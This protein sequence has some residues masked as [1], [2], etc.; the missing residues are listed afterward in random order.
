MYRSL[1]ASLFIV[2]ACGPPS[3]NNNNNGTGTTGTTGETS[4]GPTGPVGPTEMIAMPTTISKT[5]DGNGGE[6]KL[7][8][9]GATLPP[10][11]L[12]ASTLI[13]V[14]QTDDTIPGYKLFSKV[15]AFEP[16]GLVFSS[17]LIVEIELTGDAT[18]GKFYW[19]RLNDPNTFDE[20]DGL[21]L[22]TTFTATV[23]H[24]SRGFVGDL[25]P[26][27]LV[28]NPPAAPSGLTAHPG[29]TEVDL[30]WAP[31]AGATL[32]KVLRSSTPGGPYT[33][34]TQVTSPSYTHGGL[35]NGTAQYYIVK[36]NNADGDGPASLEATAT[37]QQIEPPQNPGITAASGSLTITWQPP[38][39]ASTNTSYKVYKDGNLT[40][41]TPVPLTVLNFQDTSGIVNGVNHFY[42]VTS[43]NPAKTFESGPSAIVSGFA[44]KVPSGFSVTGPTGTTSATGPSGCRYNINWAANADGMHHFA[45]AVRITGGDFI[46]Q[47]DVL[48]ATHAIQ[49][50]LRYGSGQV[51][52]ATIAVRACYDAT[53][54]I[55]GGVEALFPV[56]FD[57]ACSGALACPPP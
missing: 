8:S 1:V 10:G 4:T 52:D 41:V 28:L 20:V 22:G 23:D 44:Y 56:V 34:L 5:L 18:N 14:R 13:T 40:S 24:F 50:A 7:G 27:V 35:T 29:D 51:N 43:L 48:E 30:T 2:A 25:L 6:V 57:N 39:H 46:N 53:P 32:Y 9:S 11:A 37:P 12:T 3:A 36:G 55:C 45:V 38:P 16:E 42:E 19:S 54:S 21:L 33:A 47:P 26:V 15:W 49:C 17:P 31:V